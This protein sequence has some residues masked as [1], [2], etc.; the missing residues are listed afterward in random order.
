MTSPYIP[1]L[2][3]RDFFIV[4]RFN[5]PLLFQEKGARGKRLKI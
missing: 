2:Q 4:Y 5:N 1:L 3:E